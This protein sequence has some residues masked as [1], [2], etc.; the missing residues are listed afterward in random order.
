M[1]SPGDK[2]CRRLDPCALEL[3]PKLNGQTDERWGHQR[4]WDKNGRGAQRLWGQKKDGANMELM[5]LTAYD[6]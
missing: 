1:P 3:I 5:T 6:F 4:Q 2:S